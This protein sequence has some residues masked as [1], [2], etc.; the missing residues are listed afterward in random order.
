MSNGASLV[1]ISRRTR[2]GSA[3]RRSILLTKISVGTLQRRRARVEHARLR[4]HALDRRDDEHRAVE[5]EQRP[6]DLGDEVGVTRRVDDVDG[7]VAD[8]ERDRRRT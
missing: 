3:P 1:S 4:L 8:R 2:S 7:E 5:H 6:L